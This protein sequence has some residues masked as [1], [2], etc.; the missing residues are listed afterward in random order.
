MGQN[1]ANISTSYHLKNQKSDRLLV[2]I[3]QLIGGLSFYLSEV[4][5]FTLLCYN[6]RNQKTGQ[7]NEGSS[8]CIDDKSGKKE[9]V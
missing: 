2:A 1:K 8:T 9:C 4:D 3:L 5:L 6:Q 7:T